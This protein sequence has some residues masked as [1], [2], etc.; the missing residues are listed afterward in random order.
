MNAKRLVIRPLSAHFK[1]YYVCKLYIAHANWGALLQIWHYSHELQIAPQYVQCRLRNVFQK[2]NRLNIFQYCQRQ[3]AECLFSSIMLQI[4]KRRDLRISNTL[5]MLH[6]SPKNRADSFVHRTYNTPFVLAVVIAVLFFQKQLY[7]IELNLAIILA[8]S[9]RSLQTDNPFTHGNR[10]IHYCFSPF[11]C[12]STRI[13]F[14]IIEK[15]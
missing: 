7:K 1:L 9:T 13:S 4:K 10:S 15:S 6:R 11:C 2:H 8:V 14:H 12:K 5:F 3:T